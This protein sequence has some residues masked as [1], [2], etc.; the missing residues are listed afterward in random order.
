MAITKTYPFES[1]YYTVDGHKL[2]YVDQGTGPVIVLVHGNP[3]WSYYFRNVIQLL[4]PTHRVI[5]VDHLG[6]GLS[7]KPQDYQYTLENHINNLSKLL[8]HLEIQK[9][10]LMV[11]DWGGAIGF[12]VAVAV[13]DKI[14][15]VV[16][17]NTAAFRST[18][19]PLRI[20][21]C[22]IPLVGE[23]LVRGLN[24]FAWPATFMA[25]TK[26]LDSEQKD[27]YL[28]PYNSWKNRIA[29]HRFVMDI[30]LHEKHISYQT[31]VQVEHGLKHLSDRKIPVTIIW[32]GQD[33]CFNDHFYHEWKDRFPY[34]ETHY[35]KNGGH[36]ILEDEW[37]AIIPILLNFFA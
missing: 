19:I 31:L 13:P 4:V 20:S 15:K 3:T 6:C 5:A 18:R 37:D 32:G 34:A 24:G 36:Y 21:V 11:H 28:K 27:M 7:D 26:P 35:F 1:K 29:V 2:H 8:N 14:E 17:L 22:R 33:F 16:V 30:P 9:F 25:V 10:S 23:L 12:G